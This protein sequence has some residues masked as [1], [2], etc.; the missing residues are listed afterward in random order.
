MY[1]P[2]FSSVDRVRVTCLAE[3]DLDAGVT[4]FLRELYGFFPSTNV[5]PL[6][7]VQEATKGVP[8]GYGVSVPVKTAA[9]V[10]VR[11]VAAPSLKDAKKKTRRYTS[12]EMAKK[13][14][15]KEGENLTVFRVELTDPPKWKP[16]HSEAEDAITPKT[17]AVD[18][19]WREAL[20]QAE[21]QKLANRFKHAMT[22]IGG[23]GD[24][25]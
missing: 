17:A 1:R 13:Y 24:L 7:M 8:E 14:G 3:K 23:K 6:E 9:K 10:E 15:E 25:L 4:Q 22:T 21:Y 5:N 11:Y 16:I 2:L 20:E 12:F 18:R 19:S